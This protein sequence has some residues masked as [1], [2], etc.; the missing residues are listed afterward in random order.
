MNEFKC[1]ELITKYGDDESTEDTQEAVLMDWLLNKTTWTIHRCIEIVQ[2]LL[3]NDKIKVEDLSQ[4]GVKF[5][6]ICEMRRLL[7]IE[8]VVFASKYIS[9][10]DTQDREERHI[11]IRNL[12]TEI[13]NE[14]KDNNVYYHNDWSEIYTHLDRMDN[15]VVKQ[16]ILSRCFLEGNI[17][18]LIGYIPAIRHINLSINNL[19][20]TI[21]LTIGN[22]TDLRI[23]NL[24]G[25]QLSGDIPSILGNMTSLTFINLSGNKLSGYIPS[26]LGNLMNLRYLILS[27]NELL[28]CIPSTLGNLM[29]LRYLNLSNNELFGYIPS[30]LRNLTN[31]NYINISNNNLSRQI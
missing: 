13:V 17:P 16:I 3:K 5:V 28:G 10:E 9:R 29:N 12:L 22:L 1:Q 31:L 24:S 27:N 4:H 18:S 26:T 2:V 11:A 23:L 8:Q 21:P 15:S 7:E 30:T 14:G 6:E 20:G 25:N 19:S